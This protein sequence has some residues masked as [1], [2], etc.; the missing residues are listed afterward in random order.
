MSHQVSLT[1]THQR[2]L[3]EAL[4]QSMEIKSKKLVKQDSI[5]IMNKMYNDAAEK[6][7]KGVVCGKTGSK[8]SDNLF[9]WLVDQF[10]HSGKL[11]DTEFGQLAISICQAAGENRY[12]KFCQMTIINTLF[13]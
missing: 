12:E 7:V 5:R 3:L 11:P 10:N 6:I 1:R 2:I 9:G 13:E 8:A 4:L